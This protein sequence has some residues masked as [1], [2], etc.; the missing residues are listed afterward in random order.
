[1]A[2]DLIYETHSTTTHNEAGIATG[3][4]PGELS[5]TGRQQAR[6]LG[7]RRR[8]EDL[9]AVISSD[10]RRAV[11]TVDLA[12]D[13]TDIPRYEDARLRECNY[14][15]LNG[16]PVTHLEFPRH[17]DEPFP[18]GEN[19]RQVVART[20]DFLADL[21]R[22][23]DGR[24]VVVIAHSAKPLGARRAG[25][26]PPARGRGGAAVHLA[27]RLALPDRGRCRWRVTSPWP[28]GSGPQGR[29][30]RKSSTFG[31]PSRRAASFA[32]RVPPQSVV[33]PLT[34]CTNTVPAGWKGKV[35]T[36]WPASR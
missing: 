27:A 6:A 12:F 26:R 23:F 31:Q 24:R 30:A 3:W 35:P 7:E 14:G 11:Q 1:M 5:E 28:S 25:A 16:T 19:Y 10:L 20:R 13:G 34:G 9:A 15:A 8:D 33:S 22:D 21:V 32:A 36:E 29:P 2:V 18:G 17:I 4:L